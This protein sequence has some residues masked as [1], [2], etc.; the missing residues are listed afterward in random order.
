VI[1]LLLLISNSIPF[2]SSYETSNNII[3]V[4]DDGG[5]DYTRIQDAIDNASDGDIIYVY[6]GFYYECIV[7]NKSILLTG[8]DKKSTFIMDDFSNISF[9]IKIEAV[10]VTIS[11]FTINGNESFN[12]IGIFS[13]YSKISN[14]IIKSKVGIVSYYLGNHIIIVDNYIESDYYSAIQ[15]AG[16]G[17]LRGS[18]NNICRNTLIANTGI[19][20]IGDCRNNRI[21]DN[22][23]TSIR[24][25]IIL[26]DSYE[27]IIVNNTLYKGGI[28][29]RNSYNNFLSDNYVNGKPI[30]FLKNESNK[31]LN[32]DYG[33]VIIANCENITIENQYI[34]DIDDGIHV[35]Q[36]HNCD[37]INNK[38]THNDS[39]GSIGI[40]VISSENINI[41]NNSLSYLDGIEILLSNNILISYNNILHSG[42]GIF[43]NNCNKCDIIYNNIDNS[44]CIWFFYGVKNSTVKMN[45]FIGRSR[46]NLRY[47]IVDFVD[48]ID[49][50]NK[51]HGN[52]W[53]KSRILPRPIIGRLQR[54][55]E[56]QGYSWLPWLKFDWKPAIMPYDI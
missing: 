30:V 48:T 25:G 14:N 38:V 56:L 40:L 31:L 5:A 13:N 50:N 52:Y 46:Y 7:I 36:S 27:N 29:I 21:A 55:G 37:I 1:I 42:S 2:V 11:N 41:L 19:S 3:Y 54:K 17:L 33:Q 43:L 4:D 22:N 28:R 18:F 49:A 34:Y 45:N 20:L 16:N 12:G 9:A 6:S 39:D 23:I 10:N 32:Q 26:F 24:R 44:F 47:D 51:W 15:I 8:E 35:Y 53:N